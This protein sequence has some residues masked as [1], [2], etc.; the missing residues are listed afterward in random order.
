MK[1]IEIFEVVFTK[2][3]KKI[4]RIILGICVIMD[5][6]GLGFSELLE[7]IEVGDI[8]D[9]YDTLKNFF[10]HIKQFA[11]DYLPVF[12]I[13][14]IYFLIASFA[15][16]ILFVF[17]HTS[18]NIPID[19]IGRSIKK[20]FFIKKIPPLDQSNV[21]EQ[22]RPLPNDI[23]NVDG[24]AELLKTQSLKWHCAYYGIAHTP[25]IFRM[26]FKYGNAKDLILLHRKR[27]ERDSLFEELTHENEH[28]NINTEE[29]PQFVQS[30][31]LIVSISTTT[32]I[33]EHNL[34]VFNYSKKHV[35]MFS[36]ENK[37]HD[38]I[39]SYETA[40]NFIETII[41]RVGSLVAKYNIKT[42]HMVI[43]S[44][45]AFTFLLGQSFNNNRF[46]EV[47]VYHFE[48]GEYYWGINMRKSP[49]SAFVPTDACNM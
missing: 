3:P 38:V 41:R 28:N 17:L 21:L 48:G 9:W 5:V 31:E 36:S 25:L 45:V 29:L 1:I 20:H 22:S 8:I 40:I 46:P 18:M 34:K 12:I 33:T 11:R 47:I 2:I 44:S 6:I 24:F 13:L 16:P 30:D 43:S 26:G 32:E 10:P 27:G 39:M 23:A 14:T 4:C 7:N 42:I 49:Q 19:D 37:G 15:K 35:V